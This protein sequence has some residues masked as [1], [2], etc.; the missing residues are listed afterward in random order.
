MLADRNH[1]NFVRSVFELECMPL[2]GSYAVCSKRPATEDAT[3]NVPNVAHFMKIPTQMSA[4]YHIIKR[5]NPNYW[6][7]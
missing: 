4:A 3:A 1:A 2:Y 6:S 5:V 7:I